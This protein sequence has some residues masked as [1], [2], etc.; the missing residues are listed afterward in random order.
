[1]E[2]Q[3]IKVSSVRTFT[4]KELRKLTR[5]LVV[6]A[7][8]EKLAVIV[9]YEEYIKMQE[10]LMTSLNAAERSLALVERFLG[11]PVSHLQV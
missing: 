4:G 1:M 11:M 7:R 2:Q 5:I 6:C 10:Q 8:T 3:E 9:P